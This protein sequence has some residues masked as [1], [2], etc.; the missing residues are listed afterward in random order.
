[1]DFLWKRKDEEKARKTIRGMEKYMEWIGE[2]N[3]EK[4]M[5]EEWERISK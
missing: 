2:R 5:I 1:M 3:G 4:L